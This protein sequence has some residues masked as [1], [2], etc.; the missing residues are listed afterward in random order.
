MAIAHAAAGLCL[1]LLVALSASGLQPTPVHGMTTRGVTTTRPRQ[2]SVDRTDTVPTCRRWRS[3]PLPR[4]STTPDTLTTR[5]RT[6][7]TATLSHTTSTGHTHARRWRPHQPTQ[8]AKTVSFAD[9]TTCIAVM[10][11]CCRFTSVHLGATALH[12][13]MYPPRRRP[14][15]R[16]RQRPHLPS[17][18]LHRQLRFNAWLGLAA[19]HKHNNTEVSCPR[20]HAH[21]G[22]AEPVELQQPDEAPGSDP[23]VYRIYLP[24]P[25]TIKCPL[26]P[27][28]FKQ[29]DGA[30]SKSH[31]QVRHSLKRHIVD[32]HAKTD[33]T[34]N[35]HCLFCKDQLSRPS[36]HSAKCKKLAPIANSQHNAPAYQC[37]QCSET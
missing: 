17:P 2:Q 6:N 11:E 27:T 28:H 33:P 9:V 32:W 25:P 36:Y 19:A 14:V 8:N 18:R 10:L 24:P 15:T 3:V 16:I 37:T 21:G 20:S 22:A 35:F 23:P 31:S 1:T 4:N 13:I 7:T 5:R 29:K 12:L 34:I 30:V 26:C